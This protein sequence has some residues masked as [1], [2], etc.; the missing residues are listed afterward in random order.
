MLNNQD[1]LLA[2]LDQRTL[3][4]TATAYRDGLTAGNPH[5][6]YAVKYEIMCTG[7]PDL[8]VYESQSN[9]IGN[10][11][12]QTHIHEELNVPVSDYSDTARMIC[13]IS[14]GMSDDITPDY[15]MFFR[16]VVE[17]KP[18]IEYVHFKHDLWIN[19]PAAARET[20]YT[21]TGS[22]AYSHNERT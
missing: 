16:F 17:K 12:T 15:T 14:F 10:D 22:V 9:Y 2:A 21:A 18:H 4:H 3:W 7:M 8:T 19:N 20:E 5:N 6:R 13:I 1:A 11:D